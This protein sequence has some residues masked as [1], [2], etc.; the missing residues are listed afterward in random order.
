M[1]SKEF[2]TDLIKRKINIK[3]EFSVNRIDQKKSNNPEG[4]EHE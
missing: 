1:K 2:T 3:K 4:I